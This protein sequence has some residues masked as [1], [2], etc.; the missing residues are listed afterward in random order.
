MARPRKHNI[1][2]PNLYR[3]L[4]KRNGKVYWQYYNQLDDKFSSM[5]SD[6]ETAKTAAMELNR[7]TSQKQVD[8]AYALVDSVLGRDK[9]ECKKIRLHVWI[10]KYCDL[11]E[12]RRE[13]GELA[14]STI[15]S[16]KYSANLLREK[17]SNMYLENVGAR[18]MASI[19]EGFKDE[20]KNITANQHRS[21]WVDMFKEAQY[22]GEVPPGFNPALA[23]R[24]ISF[25]IKRG[26][27]E[28]EQWRLIFNAA[29]SWPHYAQSS[30]L[31]ALV[32]GQRPGDVIKMKFSDVWD[33]YLHIEQEK[34]GHKIALPLSLYCDAVSMSLGDVIE[35]CRDKTLS[36]HM[37]HHAS[38]KRRAKAGGQLSKTTISKMF[39]DLRNEVGIEAEE[40]KTP[41][42]F[43]EQRSLA[44]RLYK[45][46][47][48]DTQM[49][50]GH[51]NAAMTAVYH[52][53]RRNDWTRLVV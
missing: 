33:D 52:D 45:K 43:Y 37:V 7:I 41:P 23:T 53:D 21:N 17:S 4:D 47:G 6:E 3:K 34:T 15:R 13:R 14:A 38:S 40:G 27:L 44:E 11:L 12:R 22:A 18:E 49:L 31:L 20:D 42:T 46:Q 25:K 2:I 16:R 28:L 39:C 1:S 10:D 32:T 48:I 51:A 29:E 26:R 35:F 24:K 36:P 5:G 30:L 9:P 8:H 50:L 19:L